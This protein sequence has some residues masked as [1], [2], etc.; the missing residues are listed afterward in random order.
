MENISDSS[1]IYN[2]R[3]NRSISEKMLK[4]DFVYDIRRPMERKLVVSV[5]CTYKFKALK[6]NASYKKQKNII[7]EQ[8]I[9]NY[10]CNICR[11]QIATRHSLSTHVKFHCEKYCKICFW[12]LNANET[13]E[14][15]MKKF[16][17]IF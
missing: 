15:H 13:I 3:C 11:E 9:L 4:E 7:P 5:F 1:K 6:K 14:Q 17:E 2:L 12:I 8:R 10:E 16:H